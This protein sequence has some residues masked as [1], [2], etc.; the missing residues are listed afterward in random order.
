MRKLAC[1]ALIGAVMLA[2]PA[3]AHAEEKGPT[4][5]RV[6]VERS[7]GR[8]TADFS[9]DRDAPV[10][11]FVAS[12]LTRVGDRSW[13]AASWTV[14]TPGVRLERRGFYDVLVAERGT[15]PRRVRIRFSPFG[16]DLL[17]NYDPALIFT[18]GGVALFSDQFDLFPVAS[19]KAAEE[20]PLDLGQARIETGF[21]RATFRD[22]AGRILHEG[23]RK[24]EVTLTNGR[25]YVLFGGGAPVETIDIATVVDPQLP[26]WLKTEL[27][28]ASTRLLGFYSARLGPRLGPKPTV[29]VSW[30]GPTK[31]LRSMG[32]SVLTGLVVMTFEGDAVTR[33]DPAVSNAGRGFIAHEAAHF[34]LGET[35]RAPGPH[36]A[37]VMEGGADLLALRATAALDP[38]Y[39]ARGRLQNLLDDCVKYVAGKPLRTAIERNEGQA[40]YG[41]GAMFGLVA[42]RYAGHAGGD[43]FSFWRELIAANRG[44]VVD[45]E[46]W[47]AALSRLAGNNRAEAAIRAFLESSHPDPMAALAALFTDAGVPHRRD[48]SGKVLLL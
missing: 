30:A 26:E 43:F 44:K 11:A 37:W 3:G 46:I 12:G 40:Y 28:S 31:G 17:S 41:C 8:W 29:M 6:A 13:R 25:S 38:A 10:W 14:E 34:W 27:V 36:Q 42:E 20:L 39:D 7:G 18:D 5:A 2:A 35:V 4:H 22:R 45:Q 47:L 1:A 24:P 21:T 16:E 33:A 32:G 48:A 9:F 15:V 19:V 23:R